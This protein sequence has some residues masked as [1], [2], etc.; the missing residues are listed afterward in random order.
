[1][2]RTDHRRWYGLDLLLVT[3]AMAQALRVPQDGGFLVKQVVKDSI[4]LSVQ[5]IPL[6][7]NGDMVKVLKRLETLKP[8]EELRATVLRD[9]KTVELSMKWAGP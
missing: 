8:G 6:T 1:L 3:G 2:Q 9:E 7:S 5:G 4:L